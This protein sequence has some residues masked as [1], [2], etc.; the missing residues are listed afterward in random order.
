MSYK[1]AGLVKEL[2]QLREAALKPDRNK[3][4]QLFARQVR[5]YLKELRGRLEEYNARAGQE[6]RKLPATMELLAALDREADTARQTGLSPSADAFAIPAQELEALLPNR[7]RRPAEPPFPT[8]VFSE[9]LTN[10]LKFWKV[11]RPQ[12]QERTTMG[13]AHLDYRTIASIRQ[14]LSRTRS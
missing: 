8:E 6:H 13:I 7:Y 1:K 2:N 4:W 5:P 14:W 12:L 11:V 3:Q 10:L 9:R